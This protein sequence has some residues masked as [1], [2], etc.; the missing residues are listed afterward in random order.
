MPCEFRR[1]LEV[2]CV[3]LG[4][5]RSGNANIEAQRRIGTDSRSNYLIVRRISV[6]CDCAFD[7]GGALATCAGRVG[8]N[9]TVRFTRRDR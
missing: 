2:R 6:E 7:R 9:T 3:G 1:A 8:G 5:T 4:S